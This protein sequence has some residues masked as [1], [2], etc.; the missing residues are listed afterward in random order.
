MAKELTIFSTFLA[1]GLSMGVS[2]Q[3]AIWVLC[4]SRGQGWRVVPSM[5]DSAAQ[6]SFFMRRC[7]LISGIVLCRGGSPV[8]KVVT[9]K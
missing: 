8:R 3:L 5:A 7:T 1:A 4:L 9:E 2:A 6:K